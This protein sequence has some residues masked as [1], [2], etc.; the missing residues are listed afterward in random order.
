MYG[1]LYFLWSKE[2]FDIAIRTYVALESRQSKGRL[3]LTVGSADGGSKVVVPEEL[4][5]GFCSHVC[6]KILMCIG[7]AKRPI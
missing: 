5:A 6:K 7:N 2:T 4:A 3:S 1:Q